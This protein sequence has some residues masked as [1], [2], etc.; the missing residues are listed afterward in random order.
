MGIPIDK[1][2]LYILS[3][4]D[5]QMMFAQDTCDMEF[6]LKRLNEHYHN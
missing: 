4:A 6:M 1:F 2:Y 3:F 5:D